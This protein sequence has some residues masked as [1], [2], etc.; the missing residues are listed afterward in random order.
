MNLIYSLRV[1]SQFS[2]NPVLC[3]FLKINPSRQLLLPKYFWMWGLLLGSS[4]LTM[5][6]S[7]RENCLSHSQQLTV[8]L[9]FECAQLTSPWWN[10]VLGSH[11]FCTTYGN[12]CEFVCAAL[13]LHLENNI[14]L[15]SST[16]SCSYIPS[17]L[18]SLKIL[19]P[20]E[21]GCSI[22]FL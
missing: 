13:T 11:G 14:S 8:A 7:L 2:I 20:W 19:E 5:S 9:P 16:A 3:P 10:F 6:Y 21:V 12:C 17:L 22:C 1:S 15:K 18:S 4:Q